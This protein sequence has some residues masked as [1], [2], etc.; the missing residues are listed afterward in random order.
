[1]SPDA[2]CQRTARRRFAER[3]GRVDAVSVTGWE[4][5]AR[6]MARRLAGEDVIVLSIGDHEFDAPDV[7]VNQTI[8][9]LRAGRHH[10]TP[11]AGTTPLRRAIAAD[12]NRRTGMAIDTDGVAV[13]PG[14][15]CGLYAAAQCLIDPGDEVL[16]AEPMYVTYA[17]TLQTAGAVVVPVP[18]SG[19]DGFALDPARLAAHITLRTRAVLLNSPHNPTGTVARREALEGLASLCCE[20]DLWLM[21]DEVYAGMTYEQPHV[22]PCSLPGMA[23]RTVT[24]DSLSKRSAMTGWRIG[25]I[26]G[27]PDLV[28]HLEVLAGCML[29][30]V[31]PF[32]QDAAVAALQAADEIGE[33]VR[34]RYRRRRDLVCDALEAL[35]G[36]KVVRP[37]GGMF[38][39]LGVADFGFSAT[40]FATR[41]LDEAGVSVL[42]GDSFG[43]S[44]AGYV[45]LA[46]SAGEEELAEACRRIGR[47]TG[48]LSGAAP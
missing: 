34:A 4:L 10:Y 24:I 14:A 46:L 25:W 16:V 40:A 13:L 11:A 3:V 1:M 31:S 19:A 32:I 44:G 48:R 5:H 18:L 42:P 45:R 30:G 38:V 37:E 21:S 17:G 39:M 33:A 41:L 47:F 9:A 6:A 2:G 36:L 12:H 22:S 8:A 35:P 27:P 20:N 43:A 26:V 7:V 28:A 15:Q 23:D 29:F